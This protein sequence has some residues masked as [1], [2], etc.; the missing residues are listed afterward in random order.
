VFKSLGKIMDITKSAKDSLPVLLKNGKESKIDLGNISN[1]PVPIATGVK[2]VLDGIVDYLRVAEAEETK[3]TDIRAKQTVA[4]TQLENQRALFEQLMAYTF[5]ER[6]V[7]LQSQWQ[8]LDSALKN[9]NVE[10][11]KLALD[12]MVN[13]I[14]TSPF[15]S[16]TE[17]QEAFGSKDFVV[18]LE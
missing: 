5:Q 1:V 12:G 11:V 13:V 7:V 10:Q 9:G 3:R 2:D 14:Q 4:L 16:V 17:M 6:A 8:V 18:R 15:K